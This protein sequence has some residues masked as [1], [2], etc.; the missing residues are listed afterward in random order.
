MYK[1][2]I[3]TYNYNNFKIFKIAPTCFESQGNHHQGA[4]YSASLVCVVHTPGQI[5]CHNTDY[6]HINGRDKTIIVI[7]ANHCIQLPDNGSLVIRK[8]LEQ[9]KYF[10][11]I[12]IVSTNY[13][14]VHLLDNKVF[15]SSLMHG[16]NM[17]ITWTKRYTIMLAFYN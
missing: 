1:Y 5:C 4:L 14:F 16:T 8:M 10:I 12:L 17:K 3:R 11:I 9:F 6:V 15:Q 13:L 2:I 7:L